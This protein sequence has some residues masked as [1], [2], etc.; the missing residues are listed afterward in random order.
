MQFKL[1]Y[2]LFLLSLL[3]SVNS[4]AQKSKRQV[5]EARRVQLQKDQVYINALLSNTKRKE[6]NLLGDLKDLDAKI[7]TREDLINAIENES[8][9]LSNEI[10]LNQLEINQ[11]KRDLEALKKDYGNMIYKSYKSKSQNSRIMFLLSSENFFQAYKRFQYMKQYTSFRKSQG[12]DIQIK[13]LEL[14]TLTDSLKVKKNKK[15]ALLDEKKKEQS[16][17]EKEKKEQESLLSQVKQKENKY[18]RQIKQFVRE[19][20]RINAQIDKI[21]RDAIA[22]SNKKSDSR[23]KTSSTT[24]ALTPEAKELA[25][26]FELNK[27]KLDWPV[28]RG[29]VSTY[30]GKQPHPVV[31]SIT[32]QSNGVRITTDK[33]SKARAVF[34][35]VV[36]AVQV[37]SGNKKAL[38]IQHG[39]Y[40]TVYKNLENVVVSKGDKVTTKQVIGTIFTDKITGKTILD[41]VLSNNTKMENPATW[42]YKM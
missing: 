17:I 31:K 10:Y 27:G 16:V 12:E 9:E 21:I 39:N 22:A 29:F 4:V 42:I 6:I 35:G 30:F 7:N 18:K 1:A 11:N 13:T 38:L 14:Q 26:K 20:S 25:S 33:G 3:L 23:T 5:L 19:E 2:L 24:F 15:K 37:M 28:A 40:I 41:F 8:K 34:D 32:I 36:L